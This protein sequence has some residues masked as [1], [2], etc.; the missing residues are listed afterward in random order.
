MPAAWHRAS[1]RCGLT[2][3]TIAR[4]SHVICPAI[5]PAPRYHPPTK[6]PNGGS[7]DGWER[8]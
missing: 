7:F 6:L 8:Y 1:A 3:R 2:I 5:P 4:T